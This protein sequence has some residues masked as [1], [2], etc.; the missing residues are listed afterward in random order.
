MPHFV[1]GK[2]A[3]PFLQSFLHLHTAP[4]PL[5][6]SFVLGMG[7]GGLATGVGTG[8][9]QGEHQLALG[10]VGKDGMK[11]SP[12]WKYRTF[13]QSKVSGDVIKVFGDDMRVTHNCSRHLVAPWIQ[14]CKIHIPRMT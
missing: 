10:A 6:G 14:T 5:N 4:R 8:L 12:G 7:T 3:V 11:Q 9:A 13:D 2:D 1:N